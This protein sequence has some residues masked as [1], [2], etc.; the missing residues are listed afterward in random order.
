MFIFLGCLQTVH[1]VCQMHVGVTGRWFWS[2]QGIKM[3]IKYESLGLFYYSLDPQ[4][5]FIDN[6]IESQY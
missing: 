3:D 1:D 2:Y 6:I 4:V 5:I